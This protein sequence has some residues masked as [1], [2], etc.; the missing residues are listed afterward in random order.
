M[1]NIVIK[2][3]NFLLFI[4]LCLSLTFWTV[5]SFKKSPKLEKIKINNGNEIKK[6][7]YKYPEL[8]GIIP[9]IDFIKDIKLSG[10]IFSN[11]K[12][13][14]LAIIIDNGITKY[15]KEGMNLNEDL[16][17]VKITKKSIVL[18]DRG[19]EKIILMPKIFQ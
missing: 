13:K 18:S 15:V 16:S 12:N 17:L 6:N 3:A 9:K 11:E 10:I 2:T 1:Q 19:I 5:E 14:R 8:F 7:N 4:T